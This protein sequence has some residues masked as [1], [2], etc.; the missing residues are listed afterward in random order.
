MKPCLVEF[1]VDLADICLAVELHRRI[2]PE[3]GEVQAAVDSGGG[4]VRH[5]HLVEDCEHRW[6]HA[7]VKRINLFERGRRQRIGSRRR[8]SSAMMMP[9]RSV[10]DATLRSWFAALESMRCSKLPKKKIR[11]WTIGPPS[12][13]PN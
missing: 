9:C 12:D 5:R 7:D 10:S 2:E 11:S 3:D 13:P 1:E 6:T 4:I 8:W